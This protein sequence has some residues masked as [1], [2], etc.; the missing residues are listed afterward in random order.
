MRFGPN[1]M[2]SA[3]ANTTAV[4]NQSGP[5]PSSPRIRI[6]IA[7]PVAR[8]QPGRNAPTNSSKRKKYTQSF[9]SRAKPVS[10]LSPVATA[11][12]PISMLIQS[13][14]KTPSAAA[15]IISVPNLAVI[16]GHRISSPEPIAMPII[17]APGPVIFQKLVVRS[18]MSA[19]LSGGIG[20]V[21]ISRRAPCWRG[22]GT[23]RR[24]RR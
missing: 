11:Q 19:C 10:G 16:H 17:T 6:L 15:H 20:V 13:C 14:M 24:W 9:D 18:G 1:T 23:A 4:Q 7:V 2:A 21:C 5:Q 3:M 8:P 12:R 22:A